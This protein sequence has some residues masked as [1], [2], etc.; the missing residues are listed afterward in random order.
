MFKLLVDYGH[1]F[2]SPASGDDGAARHQFPA[3]NGSQQGHFRSWLSD[4]GFEGCFCKAMSF[5]ERLM[6]RSGKQSLKRWLFLSSKV[7]L[8]ITMWKLECAISTEF[9]AGRYFKVLFHLLM[10]E[11]LSDEGW[12]KEVVWVP[13]GEYTESSGDQ[14]ETSWGPTSKQRGWKPDWSV[15]V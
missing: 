14:T 5:W 7:F 4:A 9:L 8:Q 10:F 15:F 11:L 6:R 13:W 3:K 1:F 12:I 2:T